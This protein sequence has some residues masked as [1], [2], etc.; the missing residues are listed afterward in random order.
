MSPTWARFGG[1]PGHSK[2]LSYLAGHAG[3]PPHPSAQTLEA[4]R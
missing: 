1:F 4:E 3:Q 2:E